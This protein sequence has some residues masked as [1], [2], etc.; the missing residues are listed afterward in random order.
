M[1]PLSLVFRSLWCHF[2]PLGFQINKLEEH[3]IGGPSFN[4]LGCLYQI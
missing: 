3:N 1:L 4:A 2:L